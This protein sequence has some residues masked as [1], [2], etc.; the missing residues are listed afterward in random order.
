[1]RVGNKLL[2][3]FET[4]DKSTLAPKETSQ[5]YLKLSLERMN[6]QYL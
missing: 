2:D 1:M 3:R 6:T 4:E 5:N